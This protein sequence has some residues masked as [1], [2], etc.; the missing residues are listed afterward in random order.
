MNSLDRQFELTARGTNVA[1]EFAA[2]V[3][4]FLTMCYIIFVQPAM[5]SG[6]MFG[7]DTG[8]SFSG[9]M[10]AT[11]ISS[12]IASVVMALMANYPVALAPG[13]GINAYF[14]LSLLPA[15]AA[16]GHEQ[17]WQVALGVVLVSGL[18]FLTLTFLGVREKIFDALSPS[19]KS[20][21]AVGI[22]LFIASDR[23]QERRSR[24]RQ[25]RDAR[26]DEPRR[27]RPRY[28]GVLHGP[29]S[30]RGISRPRHRAE[31]CSAE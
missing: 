21:I 4:T 24:D 28:R 3:T 13:M 8:M 30:R 29:R 25:P 26:R 9:V 7:I 23:P 5:L 14:V 11:C 1:T 10:A 17:P 31:P 6:Q 16:T 15:I 22:G 27:V 18:L 20:A 2:G 19:L 12:A